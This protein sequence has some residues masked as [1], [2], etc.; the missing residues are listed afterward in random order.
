MFRFVACALIVVVASLPLGSAVRA[1]TSTRD[2]RMITYAK[3]LPAARLESGLPKT[4]FARWFRAVIG[5]TKT[6]WETNDCG[7]QTGN[8][9]NTPINPPLCAQAH[10]NLSDGRQ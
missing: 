3:N 10:A 2:Q 1:Q 8:P 9:R 7:E 5:Q 6:D 4:T